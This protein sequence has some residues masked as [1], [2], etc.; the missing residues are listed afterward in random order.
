MYLFPQYIYIW[1]YIT[2]PY[3]MCDLSD[4]FNGRPKLETLIKN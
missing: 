3:K 2:K 4:P 1:V